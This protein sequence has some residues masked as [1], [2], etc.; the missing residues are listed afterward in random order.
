[1]DELRDELLEDVYDHDLLTIAEAEQFAE[2]VKTQSAG[3]DVDSLLSQLDE[4]WQEIERQVQRRDQLLS[5]G[6]S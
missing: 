4:H 6:G 3:A 5:G 1:M 2:F